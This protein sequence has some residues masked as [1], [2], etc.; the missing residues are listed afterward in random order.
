MPAEKVGAPVGNPTIV[1]GIDL[2]H[3]TIMP[4]V[5]IFPEISD[6]TPNFPWQIFRKIGASGF[7]LN[8]EIF[9]KIGASGGRLNRDFWQNNSHRNT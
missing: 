9:P 8:C 2:I 4:K 6:E 3:R 1:A 5:P 7:C